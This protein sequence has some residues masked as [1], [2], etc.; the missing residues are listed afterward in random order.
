MK[1]LL[2]FAGYDHY[3]KMG[4]WSDFRMAADDTEPLKLSFWRMPESAATSKWGQIVRASD[5]CILEDTDRKGNW[6]PYAPES[7]DI[8]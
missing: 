5:G 7:K 2:L 4:S 6:R 3:P 8:E 1:R